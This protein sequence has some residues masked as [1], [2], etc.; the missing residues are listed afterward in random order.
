MFWAEWKVTI[1]NNPRGKVIGLKYLQSIFHNKNL[2]S[3]KKKNHFTR[4]LLGLGEG[5]LENSSPL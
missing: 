5:Q 4:A 1:W 2:S 3:I